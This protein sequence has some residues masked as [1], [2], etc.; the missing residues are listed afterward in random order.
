MIGTIHTYIGTIYIIVGTIYTIVGTI[1]TN[2]LLCWSCSSCWNTGTP[3][4][5]CWQS[6]L[7]I[8]VSIC[9]WGAQYCC[10]SLVH[11]IKHYAIN[12]NKYFHVVWL[13]VLHKVHH[14]LTTSRHGAPDYLYTEV[15]LW[16]KTFYTRSSPSSNLQCRTSDQWW[17]ALAL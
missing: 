4:E 2:F 13:S 7:T 3:W 14:L 9:F 17:G 8:I 10:T 12:P 6:W 16:I 11:M 5:P 1:Y 15:E